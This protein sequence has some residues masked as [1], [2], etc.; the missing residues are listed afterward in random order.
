MVAPAGR[1]ADGQP[2]GYVALAWKTDQLEAIR[3]SLRNDTLMVQL[4]STGAL[5]L[6]VLFAVRALL[7]RPL[8]AVTKRIDQLSAGDLDSAVAYQDRRDEIGVIARALDGF[9]AA[10]LDKQAADEQLEIERRESEEQRTASENQRAAAAKLQAAVVRLL[11]AALARLA[12]GDLTVRLEVEFPPEYQKLK[13]D[14]N[15]AMDTLQG[16]MSRIVESGGQL[17][18]S[19][20][21]IRRAADELARRTEQQAANVEETVAAVGEITAL[22]E[23]TAAGAGEAR[24]V[25]EAARTDAARSEDV[26]SS[27]IEAMAGI[28]KSSQEINKI[29]GVIDG[30]SFQTNLLALNAGVEAARA[31]DA[32]RGFVVVASEV[33]ALA[34][35]SAEAA[36]EIKNLISTSG[37]QV[38]TGAK[39]VGET[40]EAINR[41]GRQIER[42]NSIIVEIAGSATEQA[43]GLRGINQAMGGID[44]STQQNAAMAEQFTAASHSLAEETTQLAALIGHFRMAERSSGRAVADVARHHPVSQPARIPARMPMVAGSAALNMAYDEDAEAEGWEEF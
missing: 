10:T 2:M 18:V 25:T 33:R 20:E 43:H 12:E 8:S 35:R 30:I 39:L 28:E 40:G 16:S 42:I 3:S 26:V 32:G 41:I 24:S 34:Q 44:A 7:G 15:A 6:I 5:V 14:F 22:V 23:K 13:I 37:N 19:T 38:K 21:E 29:I 11:G 9:R 36:K 4:A 17:E 31:G 27:A 1:A